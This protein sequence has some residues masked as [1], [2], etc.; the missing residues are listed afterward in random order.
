MSSFDLTTRSF[1]SHGL[2]EGPSKFTSA[3]DDKPT[4]VSQHC[5]NASILGLIRCKDCFKTF[6][7]R[8]HYKYE[9]PFRPLTDLTFTVLA[10]IARPMIV[11]TIVVFVSKPLHYNMTLIAIKQHTRVIAKSF[12]A[13]GPAVQ[14][15]PCAKTIFSST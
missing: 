6:T 12:I 14:Q 5:G 10:V 7:K 1:H 13:H 2:S 3:N 4:A 8:M 9:V 15:E 11:L